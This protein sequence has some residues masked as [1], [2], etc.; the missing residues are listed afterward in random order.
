MT[1]EIRIWHVVDGKRLHE[2]SHSKLD[3]EE[4]LEGWIQNDV[5]ILADNLLVI[6]KQVETIFGGYIDLLCLNVTGDLVIVELKRDKTPREVTAQVLDYGAW[7]RDLSNEEITNIANRY[8]GEKGTLEEVFSERFNTEIPDILNENHSMLIVGSVI[9]T[10]SERIIKYLSDDYGVNINAATFQYFQDTDNREYLARVFLIEPSEVEA[11]AVKSSKR[12]PNLTFGQLEEIAVNNDVGDFYE[13]LVEKLSIYFNK[14]TTRSSIAFSGNLDSRQKAIFGL[15]PTESNPEDGLKFRIYSQRFQ[16]Y[17]N[18]DGNNVLA[19]LPENHAEWKYYPSAD[20]DYSGFEG[21]FK[22]MD[23]VNRF[24][25]GL[26]KLAGS[27]N[28]S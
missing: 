8:I 3:L 7:V 22:D 20:Q 27:G 4:R 10:R 23:E 18:T 28:E 25:D 6:G 17:F 21:F 9:D 11:K 2:L 26:N 16:K 19:L 1:E 5:S 12:K 24:I 13:V 14:S 15:I